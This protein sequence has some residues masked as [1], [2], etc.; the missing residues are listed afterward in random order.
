MERYAQAKMRLFRANGLAH[1]VL[2]LDD[3]LGVRIAHSLEGTGIERIGYSLAVGAAAASG[4]EHWLEARGT[5]VS[6]AGVKFTLAS[7]VGSADIVEPADRAVQRR[8]SSRHASAFCLRP[9]GLLPMPRAPPSGSNRPPG[10]MQRLG[11][12]DRPLVVIDYAHTPDALDKALG[13]LR[14]VARARNGKLVSVFGCGGDRDRGKR[15][16]MGA[17]ASRHADYIIVTSDNPR[18]ESPS[19]IIDEILPGVSAT[20]A[21]EV[22]RGAAIQIR[23]LARPR[24]R[25]GVDRRQGPRA[26]PRD[27]WGALAVLRSRRGTPRARGA[28]RHDDAGRSDARSRRYSRGRGRAVHV[29]IHR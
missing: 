9:A 19:A 2:N 27:R 18:S 25:R 21:V 22:D 11:G 20:Y 13:A 15:P 14:D 10:R 5:A 4:L 1:A 24:G 28:R 26:V 29:G 7:D 16:L 23:H 8:Q 17:A 3:P 12:G 6:D